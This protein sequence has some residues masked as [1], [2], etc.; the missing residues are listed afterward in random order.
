[1][2][3]HSKNQTI[4]RNSPIPIYKQIKQILIEELQAINGETGQP[5]S[6]EQELVKRFHV[7]RAPVRMALKELANEGYVYR[8]RAKGTF[9]VQGFPVKPPGL[10]LGVMDF[11]RKQGRPV[12]SQVLNMDRVNSPEKHRALFG[13][14]S[15]EVLSISR[16][17]LVQNKPLVWTQTYLDLPEDFQPNVRELEE[18]GNVFVLLERDLGISLSRGEHQIWATSAT[19]EEAQVLGLTQGDPVLI[20]ET[21]MYTRNDHFVGWRRAIH[22]AD[23]YKYA[24]TVIR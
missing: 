5:F 21:T 23:D 7:S 11:F 18:I 17:I 22:K 1:M 8:E 2:N 20:M 15:D 3:R 10:D 12:T 6:T 14:E 16:L 13:P 24:F 19:P 4:D 9:P